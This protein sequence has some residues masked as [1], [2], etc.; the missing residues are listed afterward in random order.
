MGL[1]RQPDSETLVAR[2]VGVSIRGRWLLREIDLSISPGEVVALVGPNGAGKSTLL[3]VLAGDTPPS[4]GD[5]HLDG[6]P[7]GSYRPKELALRRAVLPQQT[8]LQFSFTSW[9]VVEMG[10]GPRQGADD[11]DV[12]AASLA[13]TDS[14][15][16]SERIFPSLSGGEQ[17]RV[18]LARVLAQQY[19]LLLLDEPTA[20]L[21]LR[22]QEHVM[23]IARRLANSGATV[24]AVLHD[25]NL[26][27]AHADRIVALHDGRIVAD[28]R[29][30]ETLTDE[31]LS[32]IFE[33]KITVTRH[34]VRGC[35]LVITVP[36][37]LAEPGDVLDEPVTAV[38]FAEIVN[39]SRIPAPI[40]RQTA[41]D[42][43]STVS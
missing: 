11:D 39:R 6:R 17:G 31:L 32:R 16:V 28:G 25:L 3:R 18:S 24:V 5:V 26:A 19:P 21:D 1:A 15:H 41:L 42:R 8:V 7:L 35:P 23:N 13:Q 12:I 20:S 29:P 10:R 14:T 43:E 34:P 40:S 4:S 22:H 37:D 36:T 38:A 30:W 33:C 9:E 2:G 27:A